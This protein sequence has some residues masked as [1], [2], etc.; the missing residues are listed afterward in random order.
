MNTRT[1]TQTRFPINKSRFLKG[2]GTIVVPVLSVTAASYWL[3]ALISITAVCLVLAVSRYVDAIG[4]HPVPTP[5][6]API[7]V[8]FMGSPALDGN[9]MFQG[10]VVDE[11]PGGLTVTF[12]GLLG[13]HQTITND[14]GYFMYLVKV[15]GPGSVSA[16]T[17][18]DQQQGS[19]YAVYRIP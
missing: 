13:G 17:V 19:N 9:W 12:G 16:H 6:S 3:R 8:N 10:M 7:I 18:D 11:S 15:D 4:P 2:A 5:N 1:T 14:Y